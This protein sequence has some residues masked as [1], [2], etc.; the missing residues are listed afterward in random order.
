MGDAEKEGE[1]LEGTEWRRV[2][3]RQMPAK[4]SLM[5]PTSLRDVVRGGLVGCAPV[6]SQLH[7]ILGGGNRIRP[8]I[9]LTSI[10]DR[11]AA[12]GVL[13]GILFEVSIG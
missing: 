10:A 5:T 1:T 3:E 7:C 6:R 11:P 9:T 8:T 13:D 12:T 4:W 2:R